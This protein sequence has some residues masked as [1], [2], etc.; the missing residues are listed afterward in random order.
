MPPIIATCP[1]GAESVLADEIRGLGL[2]IRGTFDTAVES[3]GVW[4]DAVR[5]CLELRTAHRVLLGWRDC[6]AGNPDELYRE[7][8]ALPWEDV[9]F[10]DGYVC[11]TSHAD[12]P[13]IRD[14]RFATLRIK[15]A[16]VDR[17]VKACGRRP[18][19]G[20]ER[21]RAVVH[22]DWEQ[23]R[24]RVFFDLAGEPLNRRGYRLEPGSAPMMESLAAAC[25][26]HTPYRGDGAFVNPMCGSG[27]LAIEAALLATGRAPGL[28]RR[29]FG[30]MHL[31]PYRAVDWKALLREAEARICPA[32]GPILA[33][34][35]RPEAVS[36]A[37]RNAE[38][39]GV[40]QAIEFATCDFR[41]T[42][43][44]PPPGVLMLNPEYGHRMGDEATLEADYKAIGDFFKQRACG[45][46][47]YVFTGNGKLARQ[48][49][50][51]SKRRL[52]LFNAQLECRLLEFELYAGTRDP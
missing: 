17:M 47:A 26:L 41:E 40:A 49:G 11:I 23:G 14:P 30:F 25:V 28:T 8:A 29:N 1:R 13:S 36:A 50:L 31:R 2:P 38:A 3:E 24:V 22:V 48:V 6:R 18:D 5:L 9:L 27:T 10:P 32:R 46:W 35:L 19:S 20:P 42:A 12:H 16:I 34:D 7:L 21:D 52:T 15:D 39:A 37:R 33:S 51:R 44:P 4:A 45:Y 43:M